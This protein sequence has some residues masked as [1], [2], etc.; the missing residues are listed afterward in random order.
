[1][2]ASPWSPPAFMKDNNDLLHGGKLKPDFY[3]PW[4]NYFVKFIRT[5]EKEGIPIWG[6]TVQ[7][8]PMA[9]QR[10]EIVAFIQP[11]MK[12]IF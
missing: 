2:Y 5:Y 12:G 3:Q 4:A 6:I 10:W 1:M 9:T 7:N 8:E 11:K